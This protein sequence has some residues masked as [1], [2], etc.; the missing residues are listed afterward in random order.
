VTLW[1]VSCLEDNFPGMWQRWFRHQCIGIG[2]PPA[3]GYRLNGSSDGGQGWKRARE[4]L[5]RV[6]IGDNIFVTLRGHRVGRIGVVTGKTI[7]DDQWEALVPAS[8]DQPSGEM[9]RRILVRW[10][11]TVGPDSRDM[12]IALPNKARLT[13]GELRPTI[14]QIKSRSRQELV[15]AM[16]DPSNWVGLLTHF[17]YERSLSGYIAAYPHRLEDGLLPHPNDRV[18]ERV[19]ADGSRLDVLLTDRRNAPVVVECKQ[20]NPTLDH[21]KQ[22]RN[23]MK[24]LRKET[25]IAP[26]GILVHGGARKLP[27]EVAKAAKEEPPVEIVQYSLNVDF[28]R[29]E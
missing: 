3:D 17:D 9:G 14:A 18:R 7:D 5:K 1:K 19:F 12:V 27:A 25:G 26:R 24:R 21:L 2:W 29:C 23:Y 6:M 20:G 22:I 15:D 10:D 28:V 8:R 13:T 4:A 16:N 11:M